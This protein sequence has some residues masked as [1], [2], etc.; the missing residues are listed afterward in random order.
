M[1]YVGQTCTYN[2][3]TYLVR[4]T[5][6]E[7]IKRGI[8]PL[9]RERRPDPPECTNL[10]QESADTLAQLETALSTQGSAPIDEIARLARAFEAVGSKQNQYG[11]KDAPALP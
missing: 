3:E 2:G 5:C 10:K 11:C 6:E 9:S 4:M 8:I 7:A 1:A